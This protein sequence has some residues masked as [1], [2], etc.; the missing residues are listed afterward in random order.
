MHQLEEA[1]LLVRLLSVSSLLAACAGSGA[2]IPARNQSQ[3][4]REIELRL[5]DGTRDCGESVRSL[6][7]RSCSLQRVHECLHSALESCAP[8]RGVHLFSSPEG[9]P[10]RQDLFVV[11]ERGS[12][13]LVVVEDRGADPVAK[14][15]VTA[16]ACRTATW[17]PQADAPGCQTLEP[18][19]CAAHR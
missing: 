17:R 7:D 11:K 18:L 4:A 12:C 16:R 19:D 9:D 3:V 15:G 2:P 8:A 13:S 5:G 6:D 10:I 14:T 1:G